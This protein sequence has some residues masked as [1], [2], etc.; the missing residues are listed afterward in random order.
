MSNK[1]ANNLKRLRENKGLTQEKLAS[2][3]KV[4]PECICQY[5]KNKRK[6]SIDILRSLSQALDCSVDDLIK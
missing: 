3:C 4:S 1:L 5:E 2:L 6:P